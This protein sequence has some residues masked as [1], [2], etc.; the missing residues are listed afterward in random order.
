[1]IRDLLTDIGLTENEATMYVALLRHGQQPITLLS[2]KAGLNRGLGYVILHALLQ[3][4]LAT[5]VTRGKVQ[6][7]APVDPKE[8]VTYLEHRKK[9]IEGKQEKVQSMLGQL[10]AIVNPLT[11]KPKIKFFDGPEGARTVLD[12]ILTSGEKTL[13]AHLSITDAIA[14]VGADALH[15]FMTRLRK[16]GYTLR[17]IRT[18]EKDKQALAADPRMKNLGTNTKERR[19]IRYAP[20]DLAFPMTMFLFDN[21]LALLSSKSEN[22]ALVIEST[23]FASMQK[24]LFDL[25]WH[26]LERTTI[27]LGVLH[28]LSGTMAISERPLV[29]GI[30]MAIDEINAKGGVLGKR[31]DPI[32]VD[33]Q[34]DPEIFAK[35]A[36]NLITKHDVCSIIGGW[37]SASRKEMKPVSPTTGKA[38]SLGKAPRRG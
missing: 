6:Y 34:S 24:K 32:V 38:G 15:S 23:E 1:M 21:T 28:S 19:T 33:G 13:R 35:E 18:R 2:E 8:L 16:K 5:K 30:L 36:E 10:A 31:I 7:F 29:D 27:R 20:E 4:G 25:L 11:A 17:A 37:T 26:S 22:F 9:D 3:K 14:F 12:S